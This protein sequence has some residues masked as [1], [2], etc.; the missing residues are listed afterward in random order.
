MSDAS[1]GG[2]AGD[3]CKQFNV[4]VVWDGRI[5]AGVTTVSGIKR[6]TEVVT[7]REG[8]GPAIHKSPGV[9]KH[10]SITLERGIT[11]DTTFEEWANK[12]RGDGPPDRD[13][14]K[15]ITIEVYDETGA[16]VRSYKIYGCWVSEYVALAVLDVC[17]KT[18]AIESIKIE[19]DGWER[20]EANGSPIRG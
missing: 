15:E 2:A 11:H 7:H 1:D 19:N 9:S 12:V 20:V 6:T 4:R 14:R 18:V 8:G 3:P 10:E 5:V 17:C 16:L 13:F